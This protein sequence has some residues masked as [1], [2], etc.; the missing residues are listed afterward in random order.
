MINSIFEETGKDFEKAL[1]A[2]LELFADS[3]LAEGIQAQ[4]L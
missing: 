1:H 3:E 2:C 4:F